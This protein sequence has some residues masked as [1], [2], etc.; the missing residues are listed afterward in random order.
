MFP[1]PYKH[2]FIY[3]VQGDSRWA[4]NMLRDYLSDRLAKEG[5]RNIKV[6][7][8][9]I[10]FDGRMWVFDIVRWHFLHGISKGK[11]T[12]DYQDIRVGIVYQI[13][14]I[15]YAIYFALLLGW[16][17]FVFFGFTKTPLLPAL[18]MLGIFSLWFGLFFTGNIAVDCYRFNRFVKHR[19]REFFN[20]AST[21]GVRGELITSR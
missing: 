15:G 21:W 13:S 18:Q 10:Q 19:L 20:S 12:I 5:A 6:D 4:A 14:F 3:N 9:R 11:I 17:V 8:K 1:V 7:G 2:R 16:W